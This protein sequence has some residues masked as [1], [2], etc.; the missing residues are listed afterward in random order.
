MK[1][2]GEFYFIIIV[3]KSSYHT[4]IKVEDIDFNSLST[5]NL[6]FN[7]TILLCGLVS[8]NIFQG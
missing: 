5:Y 4:G 2:K 3:A 1:Y 6:D 7:E 8:P